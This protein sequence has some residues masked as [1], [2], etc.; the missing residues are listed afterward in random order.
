VVS[1]CLSVVWVIKLRVLVP[2]LYDIGKKLTMCKG[3]SMK[4]L[5]SSIGLKIDKLPMETSW[6]YECVQS[7]VVSS[8]EGSLIV[9]ADFRRLI[10]ELLVSGRLE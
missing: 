5:V 6:M 4:V 1:A 7:I 2:V 10:C 9:S 8:F 3:V